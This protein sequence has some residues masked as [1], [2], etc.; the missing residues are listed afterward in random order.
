MTQLVA[1]LGV[2]VVPADTAVVGA[3]DLLQGRGL[4]LAVDKKDADQILEEINKS[5]KA[6]II[7]KLSDRKD[8][9]EEIEFV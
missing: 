7:G 9:E 4:V 6:F 5:E 8:G 2:G 1:V 3:D